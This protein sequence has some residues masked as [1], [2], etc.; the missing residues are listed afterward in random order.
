[1]LQQTYIP[2]APPH[3]PPLAHSPSPTVPLHSK[4]PPS[5]PGAIPIFQRGPPSFIKSSP[6]P[7]VKSPS[8]IKSS[9]GSSQP[10]FDMSSVEHIPLEDIQ[11]MNTLG[12]GSFGEVFRGKWMSETVALKALRNF[13]PET[14]KAEVSVLMKLRHPNIVQ[15]LGVSK[16]PAE[17][18]IVMGE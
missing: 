18:F 4:A 6:A 1:M 14:L 15:F 12:S 11:V 16:G 3:S 10:E 13:S 7:A 2:T 5:S 8:F 9:P 17:T